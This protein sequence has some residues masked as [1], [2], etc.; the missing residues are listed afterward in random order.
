MTK[1]IAT[2]VVIEHT[3][4]EIKSINS[5]RPV[6]LVI[7]SFDDASLKDA[8]KDATSTEELPVIPN[9]LND[10][11]DVEGAGVF[12]T[13]VSTE[14]K[15]YVEDVHSYVGDTNR[16]SSYAKSFLSLFENNGGE[17]EDTDEEE[18]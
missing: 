10:L 15:E 6:E 4:G 18:S 9:D 1:E 11:T 17:I 5:N 3:D 7:T 8:V 2:K 12:E 13:M 14:D 16:V